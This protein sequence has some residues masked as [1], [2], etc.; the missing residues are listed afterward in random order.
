MIHYDTSIIAW[1]YEVWLILILPLLSSREH[2]CAK[3]LYIKIPWSSPVSSKTENS[4]NIGIFKTPESSSPPLPPLLH[5]TLHSSGFSVV[6]RLSQSAPSLPSQHVPPPNPPASQH[7][8]TPPHSSP[9]RGSLMR[10]QHL[11]VSLSRCVEPGGQGLLPGSP[12]P[13]PPREGP[14]QLATR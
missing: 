10:Q 11:D 7:P 3:M 12:S 13:A 8:P 14:A 4:I 6:E 2:I 9:N 5:C 1:L